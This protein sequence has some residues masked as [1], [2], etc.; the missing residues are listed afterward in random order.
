[1]QLD[2]SQG[3]TTVNTEPDPLLPPSQQQKKRMVLQPISADLNAASM[4]TPPPK[5]AD[6][7]PALPTPALAFAQAVP[8]DEA[9]GRQSIA[10][11]RAASVYP[12]PGANSFSSSPSSSFD[13]SGNPFPTA[14]EAAKLLAAKSKL[15]LGVYLIA[16]WTII[17]FAANFFNPSKS[18]IVLTAIML[19]N[20]LLGIGLLFRI[21]LARKIILWV[22]GISAILTVIAIVTTIGLQNRLQTSINNYDAQVST[23]DHQG[24]TATQR[25]QLN[26]NQAQ[27]VATQHKVDLIMLFAYADYG[28]TFVV[29]I[30]A[31][32]YL[33]TPRV[34][35]AF[36]SSP[37]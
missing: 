32:T 2:P 19:L 5:P 22:F 35:G 37:F 21:N 31:I 15:P 29:D 1:M 18:S 34:V 20:L 26:A 27:L 4:S 16:A 14:A 36:S 13:M 9:P 30:V 7:G 24:I 23:L 25:R 10:A 11:E 17:G 28:L 12:T 33:M 6:N 8:N 3:T